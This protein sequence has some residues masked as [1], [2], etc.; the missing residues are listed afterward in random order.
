MVTNF[1]HGLVTNPG[2]KM[3][4]SREISAQYT[5]NNRT[6]EQGWLVSRKGRALIADEEGVTHIYAHKSILLIIVKGVLKWGRVNSEVGASVTFNDFV[7]D[8]YTIST[9]E[10]FIK[11]DARDKFVYISTGVA[12]FI[13]EVSE[14]PNV[15][16]VYAFS[17]ADT[18][19]PAIEYLNSS[20]VENTKLID[21]K[22]QAIYVPSEQDE[23]PDEQ[24]YGRDV[25]TLADKQTLAPVSDSY[26]I[27]VRTG[28]ET[29][30]DIAPIHEFITDIVAQPNPF[31][32]FT[33]IVFE[34]VR[35]TPLRIDIFN[36]GG[37]IVRTL[38]DSFGDV[39]P[40]EQFELG[41]QSIRWHVDNDLGEA[42]AIG[43]YIVRF[44]FSSGL[45][46]N[47][48]DENDYTFNLAAGLTLQDFYDSSDPDIERTVIEITVEDASPDTAN[49]IDVYASRRDNRADFYWIAR[50][51]YTE[52]AQLTF[53]FPFADPVIGEELI[54]A[55]DQVDFQYI[56][57][58]EYRMYVAE[59]SSNRVYLSYYDPATH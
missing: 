51:P 44:R 1:R 49:Y 58:N 33:N 2:D 23:L 57:L 41:E 45:D 36:P 20:R 12:T 4:R 26:E 56:A 30:P 59:R 40:D 42:V 47:A 6:D 54:D 50:M 43:V 14:Y 17:L 55:G 5:R 24:G 27:Q 7:E 8:G 18:P 37:T 35:K 48:N 31:S 22:F 3:V 19:I 10:E 28:I 11:F 29:V 21:L 15:P 13:V 52:D 53:E 25:P 46:V 34:V 32:V 38:H 16:E 39:T 9:G